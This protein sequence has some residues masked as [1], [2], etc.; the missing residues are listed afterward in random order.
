MDCSMPGSRPSLSPRACLNSMCFQ[1][2]MSSHHLIL[3]H[4]FLHLPSIP[5]SIRD[6]YNEWALRIRWPKY[7]SFSMSP[8]SE[9]SGLISFSIYWFIFLLFKGLL[10]VVC[11]TIRNHQFFSIKPWAFF[12]VQF[13]QLNTTT[14]K[15]IALTRRTSVGKVMPL[16]SNPLSSSIIAFLSESKHLFISELQSLYTMILEPSKLC[17]CFPMYLPLSD[18]TGCSNLSFLNAEF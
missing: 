1:S 15:T 6:F 5:P 4:L 13:S 11:T 3:C 16:L 12:M 18:G 9:Y 2:V 10:R 7:W 14:G 17:H 8:S